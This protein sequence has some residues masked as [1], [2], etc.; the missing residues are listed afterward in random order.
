VNLSISNCFQIL[1]GWAYA[2]RTERLYPCGLHTRKGPARGGADWM[3]ERKALGDCS[4]E[5]YIF[6]G[7]RIIYRI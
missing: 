4:Q 1:S 5:G 7:E 3:S 2:K 6:D